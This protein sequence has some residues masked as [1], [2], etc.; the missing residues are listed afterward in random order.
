VRKGE[1]PEI[2]ASKTVSGSV[3]SEVAGA[4]AR[5]RDREDG[6]ATGAVEFVPDLAAGKC[7]EFGARVGWKVS[8]TSSS[9]GT[10]KVTG[11]SSLGSTA[12][13]A[14]LEFCRRLDAPG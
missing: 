10:D 7:L 14:F 6:P 8:S 2:G 9:G 4:W 12:T 11:G 3:G 13:E 5:I 1:G